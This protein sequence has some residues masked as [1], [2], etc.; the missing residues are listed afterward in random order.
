MFLWLQWIL[1]HTN[2]VGHTDIQVHT[3][4]FSMHGGLLAKIKSA[5]LLDCWIFVGMKGQCFCSENKLLVMLQE[6]IK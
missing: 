6:H 5:G 1:N 3:Q 4:F 2:E